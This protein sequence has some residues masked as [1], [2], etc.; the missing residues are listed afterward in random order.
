MYVAI[1]V[2]KCYALNDGGGTAAGEGDAT[3]APQ[4]MPPPAIDE[5]ETEL[6]SEHS[7]I[8]MERSPCGQMVAGCTAGALRVWWLR[9]C[10]EW[11]NTLASLRTES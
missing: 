11:V 4:P 3:S 2:P 8:C 5:G 7:M 6:V 10:G 9:V 1:G